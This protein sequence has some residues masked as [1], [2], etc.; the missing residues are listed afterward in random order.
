[1]PWT[2]SP[3]AKKVSKDHNATYS[4]CAYAADV[5]RE[6]VRAMEADV[7]ALEATRQRVQSTAHGTLT[8][9]QSL[10]ATVVDIETRAAAA[11]NYSRLALHVRLTYCPSYF[12]PDRGA[13]YCNKRVCVCLCVCL[14]SGA[15]VPLSDRKQFSPFP[16]L[17][18]AL[19]VGPLP[20]L[21]P[22]PCPSLPS[23][24]ARRNTR[25][26]QR[27]LRTTCS[28]GLHHE[29]IMFSRNVP[30]CIATRK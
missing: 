7:S 15:S 18:F 10:N 30:A 5:R 4:R 16:P 3:F 24:L 26:R 20:S 6:Y 28:Q 23:F 19:E 9:L 12:A 13:E 22:L 25:C 17:P 2:V 14:C 21:V 8:A 11:L 27:M 29:Y 1:V